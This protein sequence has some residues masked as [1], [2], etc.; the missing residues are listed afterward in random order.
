MTNKMVLYRLFF[1]FRKIR[2]VRYGQNVHTGT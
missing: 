1:K 2:E